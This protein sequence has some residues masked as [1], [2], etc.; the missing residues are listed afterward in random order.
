MNALYKNY[1]NP[2]LTVDDLTFNASYRANFLANVR[3]IR[4]N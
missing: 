2:F 1:Y 3:T 4:E